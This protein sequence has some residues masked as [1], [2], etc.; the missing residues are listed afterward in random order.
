MTGSQLDD[1]DTSLFTNVSHWPL[2]FRF[3]YCFRHFSCYILVRDA[4]GCVSVYTPN[5]MWPYVSQTTSAGGLS[6]CALSVSCFLF[7]LVFNTVVILIPSV[8][9][10]SEWKQVQGVPKIFCLTPDR[11]YKSLLSHSYKVKQ[12]WLCWKDVQSKHPSLYGYSCSFYI[13]VYRI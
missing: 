6:E 1:Q 4:L 9:G 13:Q 10:I 8:N 2:V 11:D 7:T 3:R 12:H 5:D